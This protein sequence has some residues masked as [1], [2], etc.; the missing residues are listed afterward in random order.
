MSN[1][2]SWGQEIRFG[3]QYGDTGQPVIGYDFSEDPLTYLRNP[4]NGLT[5]TCM[6]SVQVTLTMFRCEQM[7][8]SVV[9]W[10]VHQRALQ[11]CEDTPC[12]SSQMAEARGVPRGSYDDPVHDV[13]SMTKSVPSTPITRGPP[14]PKSQTGTRNLHQSGF[15]LAG[16]DIHTEIWTE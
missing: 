3:L 16:R 12:I 8:W 14:C 2:M 5:Y 9:D 6:S 1:K 7:R 13:I 11:F 4:Y 10:S 15:T